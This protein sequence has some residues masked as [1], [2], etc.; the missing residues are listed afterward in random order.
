MHRILA[1]VVD[2]AERWAAIE[3]APLNL[4]TGARTPELVS[5]TLMTKRLT[6]KKPSP[7]WARKPKATG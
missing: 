5:I 4:R 3:D 6:R 2:P 7:S 1:S